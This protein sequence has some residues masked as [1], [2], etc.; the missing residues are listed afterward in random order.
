MARGKK[1][2]GFTLVELLVVIGIVAVLVG[3]LMPALSKARNAAV[4]TACLA[5]MRELGMACRLYATDNRD[6]LP[7][8]WNASDWPPVHFLRPAIYS[9]T[10]NPVQDC[11]LTKFLSLG[12]TAK[13]FICPALEGSAPY[14][15]TGNQSY[16]YN[17]ILGGHRGTNI[18]QPVPTNPGYYFAAPFKIAQVKSP[19]QVALFLDTDTIVSGFGNGGNA[20]WF[21]V[22]SSVVS[23]TP[24][25]SYH[26]PNQQG[27]FELHSNYSTM[28]GT[29]VGY[30]SATW[31][32]WAGAVNVAYVDGSVRPTAFDIHAYPVNF[33]GESFMYVD[34]NHPMPRW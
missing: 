9:T 17:Q 6:S 18:E 4:R 32:R 12:D 16:R 33:Q 26:W 2:N 24:G 13:R 29:Y 23:N 31:N 27:G 19:T 8:I 25:A 20:I 3:L 21:R 1:T 22:D 10:N 34:P 7:P 30:Q 15:T 14:S 11:Y 28:G 5:R